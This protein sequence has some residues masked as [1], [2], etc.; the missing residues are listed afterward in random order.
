MTTTHRDHLSRI[1]AEAWGWYRSVGGTFAEA[2]HMAWRAHKVRMTPQVILLPVKPGAR[3][4]S[5][6]RDTAFLA[7]RYNARHWGYRRASPPVIR[8][9]GAC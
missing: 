2:L 1:M 9:A 8:T 6:L 7:Q 3:N 4:L 5:P